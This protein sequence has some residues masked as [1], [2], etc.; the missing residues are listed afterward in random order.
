MVLRRHTQTRQRAPIRQY[1]PLSGA[2]AR[3]C[4]GGGGG[5]WRGDEVTNV[6]AGE[7]GEGGHVF[8]VVQF[9]SLHAICPPWRFGY[10][11]HRDKLEAPCRSRREPSDYCGCF[12]INCWKEGAVMQ[13][14]EWR[15]CI[16]FCGGTFCYW[17]QKCRV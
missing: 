14:G 13:T 10:S 1:A 17:I 4:G 9:S 11:V 15:S 5:R 12:S 8:F 6:E 7:A 2:R 3:G 16:C